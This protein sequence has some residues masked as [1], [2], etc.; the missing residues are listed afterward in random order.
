[1]TA[2]EIPGTLDDVRREIGRLCHLRM[3]AKLTADESERYRRLCRAEQRMLRRR[4][5]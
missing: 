4:G 1:M 2:S 3:D 5:T